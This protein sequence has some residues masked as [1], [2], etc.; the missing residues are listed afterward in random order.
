MDDDE[1]IDDSTIERVAAYLERQEQEIDSVMHALYGE[2]PNW[3]PNPSVERARRTI[4]KLLDDGLSEDSIGQ[5]VTEAE[6]DA[7][8]FP[9]IVADTAAFAQSVYELAHIRYAISL[10]KLRGLRLLAGEQAEHG[11]RFKD[12]RKLGSGGPIRK[13][14]AKLL[15]RNPAMKN[16]ELWKA[17]NLTNAA[18]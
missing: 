10:G 3:I 14:I 5:R 11:Q 4:Q 1:P 13:A 15:V 2:I 6:K 17:T 7:L 16:P 8:T 9:A 18:V 12:G